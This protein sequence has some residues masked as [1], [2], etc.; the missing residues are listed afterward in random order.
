M[1][2]I[3]LKRGSAE[4]ILAYRSDLGKC[5]IQFAKEAFDQVRKRGECTAIAL[6]IKGYFDNID[7]ETLKEKW[8]TIKCHNKIQE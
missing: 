7:H 3:L 1:K 4:C 6:D 8:Q 5:N 2:T